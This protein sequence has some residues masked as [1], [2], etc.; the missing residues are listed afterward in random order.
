MSVPSLTKNPY[1][2]FP[3]TATDK[4]STLT[5]ETVVIVTDKA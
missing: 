5:K 2:S 4:E 1:A 3:K